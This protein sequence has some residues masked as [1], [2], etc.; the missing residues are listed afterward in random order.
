MNDERGKGRE[1]GKR[2]QGVP[3]DAKYLLV[4]AESHWNWD[5]HIMK[6]RLG[7]K[8]NRRYHMLPQLVRPQSFL[9]R[10][11]SLHSPLIMHVSMLSP[12]GGGGGPRADV[13]HLTAIAF[14]TLGNLT[15]NLGP[16]VGTFAFFARRNKTKSRH[17][18]RPD[19]VS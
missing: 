5:K 2:K 14:P 12:R 17:P 3:P 7:R 19:F 15:K 10:I 16:R 13:G 4:R 11:S 6:W 8:S 1:T 18:T 9:N